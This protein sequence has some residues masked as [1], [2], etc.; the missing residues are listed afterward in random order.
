M[1]DSEICSSIGS[2]L[3]GTKG[4]FWELNHRAVFWMFLSMVE[5]HSTNEGANGGW[6]SGFHFSLRLAEATRLCGH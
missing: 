2:I 3:F 5:E 4:L 1:L 6:C